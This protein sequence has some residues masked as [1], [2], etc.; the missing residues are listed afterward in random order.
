MTHWAEEVA[1]EL[2]KIGE[3]HVISTGISPSGT[4]HVGHLREILTGDA[5]YRAVVKLGG[6][7][8][9]IFLVD[10]AD[11]LRKVPA[12]IDE[13]FKEYIGVP[14]WQVPSPDGSSKSWS[15]Y[16]LEPFLEVLNDLGA[17]PEVIRTSRIYKNGEFKDIILTVLRNR[18]RLM[19]IL[20]DVTGRRLPEDWYPFMPQCTSCKRIDS[21]RVL[22]FEGEYVYYKCSACG[23][24]GKV[25]VS[26][27]AGKMPWRVEWPA[28]WRL[29]EVT[30]EPFGKDHAAAGGSYDSGSR[31]IREV[32]ER[33]P[34]YPVPYE[35]FMLKGK[36]AMSSSKGVVVS[37]Y[38]FVKANIPQ[39]VRFLYVKYL[40]MTHVEFDPI[41]GSLNVYDEYKQYE[42]VYF[43]LE[44]PT[45]GMKD[46]EYI[47]WLS[48]PDGKIPERPPIQLPYRHAVVLVQIAKDFD[49]FLEILRRQY[50]EEEINENV[51]YLRIIYQRAKSWV[52]KFAPE[53]VRFKVLERVSRDVIGELDETQRQF[54]KSL[55]EIFESE[56]FTWS[57]Q[58]IHSTIHNVAKKFG[59]S[60]RRAFG[61][62][63]MIFLGK[64]EGPRA[65]YFLY[66][67][68]RDFTIKRL[69]E[70][71]E[72]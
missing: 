21:T 17:S 60:H 57:P 22:S 58:E 56:E 61:V 38:D 32:F 41:W 40:P 12:G 67:L 55:V 16:H 52:E 26:S 43:K 1:R 5:I 3:R 20:E 68:G 39:V 30:C 33:E 19:R 35:W 31:I 34:P 44:E 9:F 50:S 65:G 18:E 53:N 63:Y 4:F 23:H 47:Y 13:S 36:G 62:I 24:E 29:F 8:R 45:H 6:D 69:K 46:V 11:P 48:Q 51:E 71:L 70:V 59:L 49:H 72:L 27:W 2:L 64:P 66:S 25:S 54:L 10:D 15:E 42:R 7:A 28:K 14:I 37:A